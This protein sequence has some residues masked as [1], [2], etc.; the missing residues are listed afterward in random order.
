M[1][2]KQNLSIFTRPHSLPEQLGDT[3]LQFN[4]DKNDDHSQIR[5]VLLRLS[6][7]FG[8]GLSIFFVLWV[9]H[10]QLFAERRYCVLV[11]ERWRLRRSDHLDCYTRGVSFVSLPFLSTGIRKEILPLKIDKNQQPDESAN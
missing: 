6:F 9:L 1:N 11:A 7:L 5:L 10:P 3:S 8:L 4:L 2:S